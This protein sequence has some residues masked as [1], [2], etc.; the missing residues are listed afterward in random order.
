MKVIEI[1]TGSKCLQ[2][3][4]KKSCATV[5]GSDIDNHLSAVRV[6]TKEIGEDLDSSD[7]TRDHLPFAKESVNLV[8]GSSVLEHLKTD[9]LASAISDIYEILS[10]QG[11]LPLGYPVESLPSSIVLHGDRF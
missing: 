6:I 7:V 4:L 2:S 3:S 1:G 11:Y 10:P 8:I 5:V 9:D